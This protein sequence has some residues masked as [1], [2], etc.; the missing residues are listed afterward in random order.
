M[1]G[2]PDY[3]VSTAQDLSPIKPRSSRHDDIEL[4]TEK[5]YNL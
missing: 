2:L 3:T 4:M 5:S 1:S